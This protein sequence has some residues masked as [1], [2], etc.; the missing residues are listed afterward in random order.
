MSSRPGDVGHSRDFNITSLK[1]SYKSVDGKRWV[2]CCS[3][4]L[5]QLELE[6]K[7]PNLLVLLPQMSTRLFT[8]QGLCE[9]FSDFF[10]TQSD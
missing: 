7:I 8:A 5:L 3:T 2:P 9:W 10:L 6:F 1:T 4:C